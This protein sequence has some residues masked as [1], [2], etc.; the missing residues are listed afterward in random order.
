MEVS[1]SDTPK[2]IRRINR[3]VERDEEHVLPAIPED[4]GPIQTAER[5]ITDILNDANLC[6]RRKD[7]Q[8]NVLNVADVLVTDCDFTSYTCTPGKAFL[9]AMTG[10]ASA[11]VERILRFLRD[12]GF[13]GLV[14]NG[15]QAKFTP[16]SSDAHARWGNGSGPVADRA[17]YVLC[18]PLSPEDRE[19]AHQETVARTENKCKLGNLINRFQLAVDV[20]D[21]PSR[22]SRKTA[23]KG[24]KEWASPTLKGYFEAAAEYVAKWSTARTDLS[25]PRHQTTSALD[26]AG[27]SFNELQAART[28]KL[29]A[30]TLQKLTDRQAT[31]IC[32]PFF[33]SDWTAADILECLEFQPNGQRWPHDA[34]RGVESTAAWFQSRLNAHRVNGEVPYSPTQRRELKVHSARTRAIAYAKAQG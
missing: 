18:Q 6:W 8:R 9:T 27:R 7:F 34:A 15:R 20:T 3:S 1:S 16:R 12:R 2:Y 10:L 29:H 23:P 17:V 25:W 26:E 14:A 11:T 31:A 4:S 19:Q 21:G 5:W 22:N 33:R 24:I 30:P 13:L 32:R 28:V